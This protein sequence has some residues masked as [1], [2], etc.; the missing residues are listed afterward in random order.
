M[1]SYIE[2]E[3]G[4]AYAGKWD[5]APVLPGGATNW[6]GSWLGVPTAAAHKAAAIA[7]VEWLSAKQQQVTLWSK[8]HW[9]TN[10][11][12][13]EDPAVSDSTNSYF[14]DAPVGKIFGQIASTMTI[15]PI[16]IYDTPI[17]S[18]FT[19]ALTNIEDKGASPSSAWKTAMANIQQITG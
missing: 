9:P 19:T 12:A 17:Q 1:M 5:I 10:K 2:S 7:L 6:G 3:A 14:N 18:A 16:G 13:A 11:L 15:P 4:N 8:G